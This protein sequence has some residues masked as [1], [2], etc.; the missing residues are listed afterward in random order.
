MRSHR[1]FSFFNSKI[2]SPSIFRTSTRNTKPNNPAAIRRNKLDR[3]KK[4]ILIRRKGKENRGKFEISQERKYI[5]SSISDTPCSNSFK[6]NGR[7]SR[8][9]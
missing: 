7:R 9:K 1:R 8:N 6:T 4:S 3:R 5:T 2:I